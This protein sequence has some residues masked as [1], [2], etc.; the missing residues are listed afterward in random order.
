MSFNLKY[1]I[2]A[3]VF[4]SPA[5][6]VV[7]CGYKKAADEKE[8]YKF[9]KRIEGIEG[10]EIYYPYDFK[11]VKI[12]K[13]NILNEG[14]KVSA[15]GIGFFAEPKW[16]NGAITSYDK[17]I[18]SEAIYLSKKA[19]E[20]ASELNTNVVIFWP[21]HDGYDYYF[22]TDYQKKWDML[23]ESLKDLASLNRNIKLAIEYKPREPRTHQIISTASKALK[24]C[25]DCGE[26][27]IGVV[28]DIG[29]A[30][31]AKENP[32]EEICYLM[33]KNRLFH[34]H[35]NDNFGDWD[36]DM[37]PGSVHFWEFIEAFFWLVK[38]GYEGWINFDICP[39][40]EDSL[41]SCNF[42]IKNTKRI[43]NFVKNLDSKLLDNFIKNNDAISSYDYL[44]N[45][46]KMSC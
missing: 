7:S 33:N 18:R 13:K 8:L 21:A 6:R 2:E 35:S 24:L 14:I 5:D 29:H 17:N 37:V 34:L 10:V 45:E 4:W 16:Q 19:I 11:D 26:P 46:I 15:V 3:S 44:W 20:A 22:Q 39:F 27:N 41:K 43:V 28:M 23:V 36:F 12:I 40:R 9:L 25:E 1:A 42:S 38:L 30:F 31:L 32:A